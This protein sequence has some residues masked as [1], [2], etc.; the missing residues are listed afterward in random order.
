MYWNPIVEKTIL[1]TR[2]ILEILGKDN[3]GEVNIEDLEHDGSY[4]YLLTYDDEG[5]DNFDA[6]TSWDYFSDRSYEYID[7]DDDYETDGG[8]DIEKINQTLYGPSRTITEQEQL[9]LFPTGEFHFP[10]GLWMMK[11]YNM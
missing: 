8:D 4:D 3:W 7:S 1:S 9:N 2:P 5:D 10:V 6:A 11:K